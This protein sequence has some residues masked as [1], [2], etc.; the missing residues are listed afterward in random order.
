MTKP[1]D[2]APLMLAAADV[3]DAFTPI[4]AKHKNTLK[5]IV[6][7]VTYQNVPSPTGEGYGV[8]FGDHAAMS[9]VPEDCLGTLLTHIAEEETARGND[10]LYA[11]KI[12]R[13]RLTGNA[14]TD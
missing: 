5:F 9:N 1:V 14:P 13:E 10:P 7:A 3:L 11:V 4:A 8:I 2:M 6:L 12:D